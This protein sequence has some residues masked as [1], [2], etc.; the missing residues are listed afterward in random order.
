[1]ITIII[2]SSLMGAGLLAATRGHL[3][4]IRGASRWA[5]ATLIQ[6]A[7]WT[8]VGP[9]R[10]VVP[11]LIWAVIGHGLLAASLALYLSVLTEFS[12]RGVR[13]HWTYGLVVM[14]SIV[15]IGLV[16]T[17]QSAGARTIVIAAC[18]GALMLKSGHLLLSGIEGRLPSHRFTGALF[19][20]CGAMMLARSLYELNLKTGIV[21]TLD[22]GESTANDITYLVFFVTATLLTFGFVLM[23]SNRHMV[24][25]RQAERSLQGALREK[26]GML[27]ETHHRVK[28]NLQ[29]LT[30]LMRL[31][32][33]ASKEP[34]TKEALKEMQARIHSVSL[35]NEMLYKTGSY[36]RVNLANYLG[37]IA[38]HLF[39]TQNA[40]GGKVRLVQE[41]ETVEVPTRQ[42]I[43]CGL[44]VNELVTNSL[45]HG[46]V[47]GRSG[48]VRITLRQEPQGQVRIMVSDNG[49]GLPGDF[50]TK[51]RDSLG[52]QLV[53][54]LAKQLR[55]DLEVGPG[56]TF[57]IS[58]LPLAEEGNRDPSA[59]AERTRSGS[60]SGSVAE[61]HRS[62][63][64]SGT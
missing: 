47:D 18:S 17:G 38:T 46:F 63:Q 50:G 48:E 10:E 49:V 53:S 9:L 26:E 37:Q 58:F 34:E 44:I 60:R 61:G 4:E 25:Q 64:A 21:S 24:E 36:T 22:P 54:D 13:P 30:S 56:A 1:V 20:A 29:L 31:T 32:A 15:L 2:G 16:V 62:E 35:L 59:P 6:A 5:Q 11:I 12:G 23:V 41:L 27:L 52:L 40:K 51:P 14:Q 57:T 3:G 8:L 7:G 43:P 55:S 39:A 28:N 42:A 45:K 33:G 19:G